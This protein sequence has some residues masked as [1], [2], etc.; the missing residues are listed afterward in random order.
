M[1]DGK[2]G[3]MREFEPTDDVSLRPPGTFDPETRTAAEAQWEASS[4]HAT[5]KRDARDKQLR[6]RKRRI[7]VSSV[8]AVIVIAAAIPLTR[9]VLREAAIAE[10][11]R[12]SLDQ[13]AKPV[14]AVGFKTAKEWFDVPSAGLV[15]EIPADSCSAVV[16]IQQG[17]DQPVGVHVERPKAKPLDGKGV[18]WCSCEAERVTVKYAQTSQRIALRWLSRHAAEVGGIEVLSTH[19]VSPF[20]VPADNNALACADVAFKDWSATHRE[21]DVQKIDLQS[22]GAAATLLA[23]GFEPVGVFAGNATFAVI[24]S[25]KDRCYLATPQGPAT[26]YTVRADDGKRLVKEGSPTVGWCSHGNTRIHSFWRDKP[27]SPVTVVSAPADKVG[28]L[29]GLRDAADRLKLANLK[30]LFVESDLQPDAVAALKASTVLPDSIMAPNSTGLPG[31]LDDV[32]VAFALGGRGS[33]L[34]EV[35]PPVPFACLPDLDPTDFPRCTV[36]VQSKP[37]VW[38][39][40]ASAKTQGAAEAK[41][42]FWMALFVGAREKPALTAAVQLLT[43]AR[44]MNLLGFE[45][46][47]SDGVLDQPDG[48]TL[49]G[50]PEKEETVSVGLVKRPPWFVP[51]SDKGDWKLDGPVKAVKV[52]VGK[53]VRVRGSVPLGGDPN[54]RRVVVWR[55]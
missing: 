37:Q 14:D 39:S 41:Y 33:F 51:L 21:A 29:T 43:F 18:M 32:I 31:H 23:D 28:G 11:L 54:S 50:R 7:I 16:A 8:A 5:A 15:I 38:R 12:K 55:R 52:E 6:A 45:P 13:V 27:G 17:S 48:A 19:Q 36:C 4:R 20:T 3:G 53:Q 1:G 24:R 46:T 40:D 44:R 35:T 30:L 26:P 2:G 34:P 10:S 42:P 47:I 25:E 22:P 49:S 9:A